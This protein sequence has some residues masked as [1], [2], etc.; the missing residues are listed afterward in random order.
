[1]RIIGKKN[2]HRTKEVCIG[3]HFY[4]KKKFYERCYLKKPTLY[5]THLFVNRL[6]E[7]FSDVNEIN[8]GN[9]LNVSASCP[10]FS[11]YTS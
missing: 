9:I 6:Q 11:G 1:M 4:A 10:H 5:Q 7:K 2:T 3:R 8:K